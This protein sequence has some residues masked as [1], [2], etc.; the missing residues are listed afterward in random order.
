M[1]KIITINTIILLWIITIALAIIWSY[2]NP[3]K[4]ENLKSFYKKQKIPLVEASDTIAVKK[5]ANSFTVNLSQIA[6]LSQKTAFI[7]YEDEKNKFDPNKLE[8][9]TQNG[10]FIKNL[11]PT[12]LNL[13]KNFTLQRNGGIKTIFS[14]KKNT[15][16]LV[17]S[18]KKNC[19]Y[20]S[21]IHLNN[22]KSLFDSKCLPGLNKNTDFNGLGSSNIHL[23]NKIFLSIGAP[24]QSSPKIAALAQDESSVFG[25]ILAIN[26]IDLDKIILNKEKKLKLELFS[27]GHRNPQGMTKIKG[28]IF[29]VEHGPLGGDELNKIVI[30]KN[31]GWPNVSYGTKYLY[32]KSGKSYQTNHEVNNF[33]EPLFALVPSVGISSLN[34]CPIKLRNFYNKHCLIALSLSGNN[35]RPGKSIIIYL[36]DEKMNKVHSIEKI[37]LGEDYRF[38]HFVTNSKNE[39]YEDQN[40]AIYV[41]AD[42]KGIYRIDFLNFR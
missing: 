41:S 14:Y 34:T 24:E 42:K 3:E 37:Y 4:V 10:Y 2:E 27:I 9:F 17:S 15:F 19:F 26:K 36:L 35:L 1:K 8:I 30:N 12:K 32:D 28:S 13:P 22:G 40:G 20:A 5:I 33:E 38:R 6:S 29:S 39:L 21:I 31:Y 18:S 11:T 16:A 23:K 25:K 7:I